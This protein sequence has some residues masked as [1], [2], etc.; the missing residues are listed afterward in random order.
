MS[1]LQKMLDFHPHQLQDG[2]WHGSVGGIVCAPLDTVWAVV[3]QTKRLPEW[4]P[5]VERCTGL[6]GD[7]DEPGYVRLVSGFMFPKSDGERSWIKERLVSLDSSSHSYVYR[8][9]ASNVGLGGSV[10]SLNLA[11]YGHGS[12]LV[13]WS[14]DM[15]LLKD[16][17]QDSIIDYLGFLYKSC[18]NRIEGAVEA[19]SR[20]ASASKLYVVSSLVNSMIKLVDSISFNWAILLRPEDGKKIKQ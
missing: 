14:F 13:R 15:N 10:N 19:E 17:N 3:S 8:M 1:Q 16:A 5:M 20:N 4:M 11:D 12:T 7:E 2:K 6:A 18:I 9:E